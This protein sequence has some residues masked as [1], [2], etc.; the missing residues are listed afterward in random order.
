VAHV[1]KEVL[2]AIPIDV[3]CADQPFELFGCQLL[4]GDLLRARNMIGFEGHV[5]TRT[6]F[7]D[8]S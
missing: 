7:Q 8:R 4:A 1:S 3:A 6:S 2:L 5:A